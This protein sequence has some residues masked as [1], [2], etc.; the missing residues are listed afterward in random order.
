M[1]RMMQSIPIEVD[2]NESDMSMV[3]DVM[4]MFLEGGA[5]RANGEE[6]VESG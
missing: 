6:L 3:N 5:S 1:R 2:C 4:M